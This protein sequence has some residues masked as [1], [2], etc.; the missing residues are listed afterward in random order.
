MILM[1]TS[2]GDI[3][4]ELNKEKAPKTVANFL[5]YAESG[6]YS[7]TIFHRVIENFMI[8]CGGFDENMTQKNAPY[9]V[10]NEADN[11]LSND[12]GSVAMA[13]TS[14]PHSGGAQFFINVKDNGFLNHTAKTPQGWGYCVFG[15]VVEGMDVVEK[16]KAVPTGNKGMHGD[17]PVDP[18]IITE[19]IVL[20]K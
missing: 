3:K 7:G 10:E 1:K 17:V 2:K 15:K 6:H 18:V 14:D 19:V 8:Q 9:T 5:K 13:R 11:G 12:L 20:E 16:I 4:L